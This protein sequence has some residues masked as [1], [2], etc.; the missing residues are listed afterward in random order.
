[1]VGVAGGGVGWC[2]LLARYEKRG[3]GGCAVGLHVWPDTSSRLRS[4][5]VSD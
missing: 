4:V 1:M 5:I 2:R 3:G